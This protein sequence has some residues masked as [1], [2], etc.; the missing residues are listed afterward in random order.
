MTS[1][2][3]VVERLVAAGC[4]A[5]EQEAD[6]F[7]ATVP[8]A[9]TLDHWVRR[10]EHGEPHSWITGWTMFCGLSLH[11]V[12]GV[13]VPRP[14]SEQLARRAAALLPTDGR[15]IDL[16]A[17]VGAVGAFL[18]T[19]VPSATVVGVEL[20][21]RAALC[22][23]RN[24]VLTVVGDLAEPIRSDRNVDVVSA[25]AP[26]VPTGELRHL[27]DDVRRFEPSTALDGGVDGLDVVRRVIIDARRLLREGG[28][29]VIEL[30]ADQ[31]AILTPHL[32]RHGFVDLVPW[33]DDNG[34][35]RGLACRLSAV[36]G[37]A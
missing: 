25:I 10:R 17:G 18:G 4:V 35:L 28:S 9:T 31:D 36:A 3:E 12:P 21:V 1:R 13:Y 32:V 37:I 29:L 27:P 2:T 19:A 22:A 8:D 14:Q 26:Y 7:L 24:G 6:D 5:A 33:H 23:R 16:C 34:D 30:G 15:A 11:V 20:D